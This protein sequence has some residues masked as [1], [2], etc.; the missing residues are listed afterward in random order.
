[1]PLNSSDW[2]CAAY[3]GAG[4]TATSGV[5]V[6][7]ASGCAAGVVCDCFAS[8]ATSRAFNW[9]TSFMSAL[10]VSDWLASEFWLWQ[11]P[12]PV[13]THRAISVMR[14]RD[15]SSFTF[16]VNFLL[17]SFGTLAEVLRISF[18]PTLRFGNYADSSRQSF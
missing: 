2:G 15:I 9:S 1:M 17:L 14:V 7:A 18:T 13:R 8:S 5:G 10:T 11:L 4:V 12:A 16:A 3:T 6:A